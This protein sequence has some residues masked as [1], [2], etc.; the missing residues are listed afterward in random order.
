K[1]ELRWKSFLCGPLRISAFSALM[2]LST[3]RYAEA[4]EKTNQ[5][6]HFLCKAPWLLLLMAIDV[7]NALPLI[8][9]RERTEIFVA[10]ILA[11]ILALRDGCDCDPKRTIK[12]RNGCDQRVSR[13]ID[14]G[15]RVLYINCIE[16]RAVGCQRW[17]NRAGANRNVIDDRVC[18]RVDDEDLIRAWACH[19]KARTIQRNGHVVVKYVLQ[20]VADDAVGCGVDYVEEF[21]RFLHVGA[22]T[23][24]RENYSEGMKA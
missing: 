5:I 12:T 8:R 20:D 9:E 6:C 19:V 1:I 7:L 16:A 22:R 21:V 17:K 18:A 11:L 15:D 3:Q 4:A 23:I 24:R 14:D 13:R 10:A 2:G